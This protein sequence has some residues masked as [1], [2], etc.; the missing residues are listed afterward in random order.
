MTDLNIEAVER[1]PETAS[2]RKDS[3]KAR[4]AKQMPDVAAKK[5]KA[6]TKPTPTKKAAKP[7]EG[8]KTSKR[9][10][11]PAHTKESGSSRAETKGAKILRLIG[12][13]EGATLTELMTETGWQAH[14]MRGFLSA[15][16]K[17]GLKLE[18]T[19]N[20]VGDRNYTIKN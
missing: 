6:R 1:L 3:K 5:G 11:K 15:S 4:V 13:A 18:S 12:R 20:D 10:G 7:R 16:K 19:K 8:A 17:R 2:Q 14:S 9:A